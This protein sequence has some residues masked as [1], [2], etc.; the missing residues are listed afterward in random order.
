MMK[1]AKTV[2]AKGLNCPMP[3]LKLKKAIKDVNIGDLVELLATDPGSEN[4]VK[5]FART[6]GHELIQYE[7]L[8]DGVFRYVVKRTK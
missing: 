2:D 6:T 4:D 1:I 7:K 8:A 3:I 5:A